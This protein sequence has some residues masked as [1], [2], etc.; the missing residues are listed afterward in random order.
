[1][2]LSYWRKY[3][4][5]EAAW[6]KAIALKPNDSLLYGGLGWALLGQGKEV[7]AEAAFCKAIALK[8]DLAEA[9]HGLCWAL[10]NQGKHAEAEAVS[11][12]AI[13]FRP[14][15]ADAHIKRGFT[16]WQ[17]GRFADALASLR[18]GDELGRKSPE[19]QAATPLWVREAERLVHLA[20]LLPGILKGEALPTEPSDRLLLA[21]ICRQQ[22]QFYGRAAQLAAGAFKDKP[23]L[24][25]DK[26]KPSLAGAATL[27]NRYNAA[28]AAALAGC[29]KGEDAG[30]LDDKER[31]HWRR[32]A[33]AW[34]R[35]DFELCRKQQGTM[36]H[37][38][39]DPA[40][41]GVRDD[42]A[43]I[44]LPE[45]ERRDWLKLWEE[46]RRVLELSPV[47]TANPKDD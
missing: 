19:L 31:V 22:K 42:R 27:G 16:L 6:R 28:R 20:E 29:G 14:D 4:D 21:D 18:R 7:E 44:G 9:Y 15:F 36:R 26:A 12:K 5:A 39:N 23:S 1:V 11:R 30:E 37:W 35:A 25:G 8:P 33:L 43:L 47:G 17:L 40:L 3:P 2:V 10:N 13:A 24:A 45:A 38:L 34:L 32:Q 41:A 46:V